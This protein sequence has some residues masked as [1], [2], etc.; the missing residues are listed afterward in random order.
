MRSKSVSPW[1]IPRPSGTAWRPTSVHLRSSGFLRMRK[2][3]RSRPTHAKL[4][5][6]Q[7]PND[8]PVRTEGIHLKCIVCN[9]QLKVCSVWYVLAFSFLLMTTR[10]GPE[11]SCIIPAIPAMGVLLSKRNCYVHISSYQC[12]IYF[13]YCNHQL[14]TISWNLPCKVAIEAEKLGLSSRTFE[15]SWSIWQVTNYSSY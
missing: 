7:T 1:A 10:W 13:V 5:G 6:F 3:A 2:G 4:H 15:V 14:F 9:D 8:Q 11:T 12:C